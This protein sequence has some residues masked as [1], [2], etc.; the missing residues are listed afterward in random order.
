MQKVARQVDKKAP[1]EQFHLHF[2]GPFDRPIS[3]GFRSICGWR[4]K[5]LFVSVIFMPGRKYFVSRAVLY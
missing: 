1:K 5:K 4:S 3:V 2:F